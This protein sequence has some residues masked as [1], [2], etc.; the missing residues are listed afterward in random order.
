[1]DSRHPW[2]GASF[3]KS[4]LARA[5]ELSQAFD[6]ALSDHAA[7]AS[8]VFR[9]V[10]RSSWERSRQAGLNPD[11]HDVPEEPDDGD[12]ADRWAEHPLAPFTT[13]VEQMLGSF[14]Y[15]AGHIVVIADGDGRLLWS[16][17]HPRVLSAS[18]SIGFTPGRLWSE[19]A[20]GT[21]GV[22]TALAVDHPIQIFASE[23]F[24]KPVHPWVC[25][26]APVHDP[27]T[28]QV[29]GV[30]DVSS[31]VRAAHPYALAL[32]SATANMVELLLRN[33]RELTL[34]RLRARFYE[35]LARSPSA[36]RALV[37]EHGH[38]L[39]CHPTA[40][41]SGPLL[42]L[43]DGG[44]LMPGSTAVLESESLGSGAYIVAPPSSARAEIRPRLRIQ[45]LGRERAVVT[46]YGTELELSSRRSE[47]LV[48]LALAPEGIH[49]LELTRQLY[50]DVANRMT[51]RAEISRL[52][53]QLG[54]LIATNPYRLTADLDADFLA[55]AGHRA[56]RTDPPPELI[57]ELL[58]RST[59]PTIVAARGRLRGDG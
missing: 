7:E 42:R 53:R 21:N 16:N 15:D 9:P 22:G 35:R 38:V 18:E 27:A 48:L 45:A 50:G 13:V 58:P 17:G 37:D 5:H 59:N 31:G 6:E 54:G 51:V 3:G 11:R 30:I 1:M 24:S 55:L 25:S 32:V 2:V 12:A 10:V 57:G 46:L 49:A 8:D 20:A 44:W 33:E 14:A 29:L 47:L 41:L 34:E 4:A 26:G 36:A 23:H 52:R 28:G 40:W 56:A 43:R 19:Q 39:A